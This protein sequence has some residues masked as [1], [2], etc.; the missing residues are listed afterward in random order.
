MALFPLNIIWKNLLS[1]ATVTT[2]VSS[3]IFPTHIATIANPTYP[4]VCFS[5]TGGINH[6]VV[7][8]F[9]ETDFT[10]YEYSTQSYDQCW[11]IHKAIY[12]Y[13]HRRN[14]SESGI[15]FDCFEI[16]APVMIYYDEDKAYCLAS[17]WKAEG[18][19]WA[20]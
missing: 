18:L 1:Q 2:F 9:G 8:E 11:Q 6:D 10:I 7:K 20:T 12:D 14:F 17:R 3:R 16:V 13:L 19:H 5:I 4:L 15:H